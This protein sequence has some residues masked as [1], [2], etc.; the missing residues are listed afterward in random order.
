MKMTGK[1][2]LAALLAACCMGLGG[3]NARA[4]TEGID[5]MISRM[6]LR[7]KVG[8][9]FVIR[10]EALDTTGKGGYAMLTDEMRAEYAEY[11]CGGF[12]LF[13]QNLVDED[14]LLYLTGCLH[15]LGPVR[16]LLYIDEEGGS[17]ARIGNH[18]DFN[19]KKVLP[20]GS[21][22]K[23]GRP[24]KAKEAGLTIGAYLKMYGLDVD[25]A[26]VADVNTNPLNP[27]IGDRAF[28][29]RPKLA[30][31]MVT[32][33][34]SGLHEAGIAGCV[35]HFP[36]HGD[37]ATDTHLG[38]AESR[39]TWEELKECELIPFEAGIGAGAD[40]VMTAHIALPNV[41]GS[42]EPATVSSLILSEK[43]RGEM[44]YEGLIVTDALEMGA[45]SKEFTPVEACVRCLA[46]GADILLLPVR[47]QEAFDGV[48]R[49]V[50]NGE[51][52]E[53]RI[54]E[55]VRRVLALKQRLFGSNANERNE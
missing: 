43:L 14:Q 15:A 41:T 29:T 52:T 33:F 16:P 45:I 50:E 36:G 18:P 17:V 38:Y 54:D 26:P 8:Q 6:T 10:P 12:C 27:V 30:A 13:S 55:S 40:M 19:V 34:L 42:G 47:Y 2:M 25:F 3:M 11:P 20:M 31:Q 24:E 28:G 4:E 21:I 5:V 37:T 53:S 48:V 49:A 32:A 39:K 23:T 1:R 22:A 35:K 7:E 51:I 44:G 9:L 46:A